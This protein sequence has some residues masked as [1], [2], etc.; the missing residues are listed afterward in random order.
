M[1]KN[2]TLTN[3]EKYVQSV[4]RNKLKIRLLQIAT[5]IFIFGAWELL[6]TVGVLDEFLFSKPSAII[7]LLIQ[8]IKSNEI[9][10]HVGVSLYETLLGLI[11]GTLL[12]IGLAI[13]LWFSKTLTRILDPFLVVLNAL[14]KS[15]GI[16]LSSSHQRNCRCFNFIIFDYDRY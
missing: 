14:P 4:K 11:I 13:V 15:W 1:N 6:A 5:V 16:T 3:Q 8:Y 9:F 7:K 2:K 10:I 12:G